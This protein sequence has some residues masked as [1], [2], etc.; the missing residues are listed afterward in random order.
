MQMPKATDEDKA[1]FAALVVELPG[2]ETKPMFGQLGAFVHGNMFMGLF[3]SQVGVKLP[4]E[5]QEE[6]LAHPEAGPFGPEDR[7]MGGYVTLPAGWSAAEARP[8]VEK[9]FAH[10]AALPPKKK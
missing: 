4:K 10:A 7:P 5:E 6:L 9:A 3:G 8:W 2:G 1:R